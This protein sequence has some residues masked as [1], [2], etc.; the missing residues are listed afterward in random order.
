MRKYITY[1]LHFNCFMLCAASIHTVKAMEETIAEPS[2]PPMYEELPPAYDDLYQANESE[3][4]RIDDNWNESDMDT[5]LDEMEC[6]LNEGGDLGK[7]LHPIT[8]MNKPVTNLKQL[9]RTS[10]LQFRMIHAAGITAPLAITDIR[11]NKID[12]TLSEYQIRFLATLPHV[13]LFHL[14]CKNSSQEI[15]PLFENLALCTLLS[16]H[17]HCPG[18]DDNV[19]LRLIKPT[20]LRSVN[21]AECGDISDNALKQFINS[22]PDTIEELNLTGAQLTDEGLELIYR[23]QRLTKL[24]LGSCSHLSPTALEKWLANLPYNIEELDLANTRL[25][26]EGLLQVSRCQGLKKLSIRKCSSLP[27]QATC[28][29]RWKLPEGL[30]FTDAAPCT[31][32]IEKSDLIPPKMIRLTSCE[33]SSADLNKL[34][35]LFSDTIEE[36]CISNTKLTDEVL[37]HIARFQGL[38]RLSLY[39]SYL[40]PSAREKLL[41]RIPDTIEEL[42]L[43]GAQLSD[44]GLEQIERFRE[45]KGLSIYGRLGL[46]SSQLGSLLANLPDTIVVLDLSSTKLTEK[47]FQMFSRFQ[48]LKRLNIKESSS[49]P[50]EKSRAYAQKHFPIGLRVKYGYDDSFIVE[51]PA[52][53]SRGCTVS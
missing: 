29:I 31:I 27:S 26:L 34:L 46:S 50:Y 8:W 2:A 5:L 43:M 32:P 48:R 16:L 33:L 23:F 11:L 3:L 24:S 47:E 30:I 40:S 25:T 17:F 45:L 22:L 19:L 44:E 7:Y 20:Q 10:S 14:K 35:S 39:D 52:K 53:D 51:R 28:Y 15:I 12:G 36:L 1:C 4:L 9:D 38:K 49:L 21:L 41:A 6:T 37:E 18:I 13:R 42:E